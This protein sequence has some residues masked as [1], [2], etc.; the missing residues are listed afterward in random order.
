M[1]NAW[2]LEAT[3]QVNR[4]EARANALAT[5]IERLEGDLGLN[6]PGTDIITTVDTSGILRFS[7]G[8]L[9]NVEIPGGTLTQTDYLLTIPDPGG[10]ADPP[11][12]YQFTA[13]G[14]IIPETHMVFLCGFRLAESTSATIR[15]YTISG[16]TITLSRT[17]RDLIGLDL[18]LTVHTIT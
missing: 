18:I 13:A 7:N 12:S 16:N 2:R 4:E 14:A 6:T 17:S 5:R 1:E 8:R 9:S 15:D 3:N 11:G 10:D